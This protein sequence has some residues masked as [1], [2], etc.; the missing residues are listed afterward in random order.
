[1]IQSI[2]HKGL[3]RLLED[4]DPRRV[5]AEHAEKA[6]PHP[7]RLDTAGILED[8]DLP[9]YRLNALNAGLLGLLAVTVRA[10]WRVVFRRERKA[11]GGIP[12][13]WFMQTGAL[14]PCSGGRRPYQS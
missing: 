1:M 6:A 12:R 13:N 2:R 7:A 4:H 9:G 5:N 11:R 8:M 3:S 10:N 14:R